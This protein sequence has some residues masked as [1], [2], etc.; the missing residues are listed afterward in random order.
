MAIDVAHRFKSEVKISTQKI[1]YFICVSTLLVLPHTLSQETF[2]SQGLYH[3][4]Q[5]TDLKSLLSLILSV[6]SF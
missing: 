2:I 3:L 4:V 6:D 1:K 5:R